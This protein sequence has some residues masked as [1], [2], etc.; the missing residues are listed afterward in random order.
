MGQSAMTWVR[1]SFCEGGSCVEVAPA[2]QDRIAVRDGKNPGQAQLLMSRQDW[3]GF[4]DGI[5]AGDFHR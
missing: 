2:E 3:Y 1:S 5:Q 4:L